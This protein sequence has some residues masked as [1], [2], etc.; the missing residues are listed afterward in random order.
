MKLEMKKVKGMRIKNV[1][2]CIFLSLSYKY[3]R[4]SGRRSLSHSLPSKMIANRMVSN[5]IE[6]KALILYFEINKTQR[7]NGRSRMGWE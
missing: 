5:P 7:P 4:P 1:T 3:S 2:V 6:Q